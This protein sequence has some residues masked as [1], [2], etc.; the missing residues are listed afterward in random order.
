MIT[1]LI[2]YYIIPILKKYKTIAIDLSKQ[3][4]LDTRPKPMCKVKLESATMFFVIENSKET[5][6]DFSQKPESIAVLFFF[7][8]ILV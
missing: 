5:I 6:S 1:Q 4:T 2:V 7:N 8:I 3:Q